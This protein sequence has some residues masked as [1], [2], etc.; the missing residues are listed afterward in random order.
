MESLFDA[1]IK[2]GK[3]IEI[4]SEIAELDEKFFEKY[5]KDIECGKVKIGNK[6]Y[7][8]I[9]KNN[10]YI[11]NELEC[12]DNL[13]DE[14]ELKALYDGLTRC[15]NKRE[16]EEF[17]KKFLY[18]FLRYKKDYF[19]ILMLDIDHFKKVNDTYGHLA[20]D[21][22]LKEVAK[23]IKNMIRKSDI[24]GRFGGEEFII[25]LP[26][27]KLSGAMKLAERLRQAIENYN[28]EFKGQKIKITVSIGITSVGI[29][30]SFESLIQRVDEALYEAKSK[31]R[32]RVEYR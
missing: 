29:N 1:V 28:F 2:V 8:V 21:F 16:S 26:N 18:N 25:L 30:D 7:W 31:G 3:N 19:T 20:G 6:E 4:N 24:C 32:N 5:I 22:I 13:I 23:I 17:I 14:Y 9:K 27:N 12:L 15:Y 11:V 10:V